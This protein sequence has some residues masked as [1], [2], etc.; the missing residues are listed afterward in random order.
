[1]TK[2]SLFGLTLLCIATAGCNQKSTSPVIEPPISGD[3]LATVSPVPI[4]VAVGIGQFEAQSSLRYSPQATALQQMVASEFNLVVAENVMKP[5]YLHPEENR[6]FWDDADYLVNFAKRHGMA[7]HGHTLV[8]HQALPAWMQHYSG[9]W[10]A[11]LKEH[12]STVVSRY[13]ADIASWDVVNEAFLD[14]GTPRDSVWQQHVPDYIAKAFYY[15]NQSD[16]DG[17]WY[18]N[19]Y[20]I[21]AMPKKLDAVLAM[22]KGLRQRQIGI[23]G[24]GF[25]MHIDRYWPSL[26]SIRTAF[27]KTVAAGLNVRISEL[28]I[29]INVTGDEALVCAQLAAIQQQRYHDIIATY[30]QA[31][32]AEYRAGISF[33]GVSD[34][35]SW[36]PA[37]Y[38]HADW[39]LLFDANLQRKAAW[40]GVYDALRAQ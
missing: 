32:P 23:T 15:A 24:I 14:D 39:P 11:M 8:W 9:N 27:E 12:I 26:E 30:L 35:Y 6:Y 36:V 25:Q 37:Y 3:A 29:R 38:Q 10:D 4:G 28:D 7:I 31:V 19:D 5:Q 20:N 40:Q 34:K 22:A 1:M 17:E 18:Y 33:W 21:E 16:P 2:Q 13:S